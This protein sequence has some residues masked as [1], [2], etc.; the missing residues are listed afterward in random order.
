MT[1]A[2]HH[3]HYEQP[4]GPRSARIEHDHDGG[5]DPHDHDGQGLFRWYPG[6]ASADDLAGHARRALAELRE[7]GDAGQVWRDLNSRTTGED[8]VTAVAVV[9]ERLTDGAS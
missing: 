4:M 7:G 1:T 6:P 8:Y 3:Y 2:P 9:M 5:A